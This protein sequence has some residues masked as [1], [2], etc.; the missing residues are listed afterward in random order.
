LERSADVRAV[1]PITL[2]CD[3]FKTSSAPGAGVAFNRRFT[4]P[5]IT[6]SPGFVASATDPSGAVR[7]LRILPSAT[8]CTQ[9]LRVAASPISNIQ[10]VA[11]QEPLLKNINVYPSP[12]RGLVNISF[13]R[14]ELQNAVITVTDQSGRIVYQMRNK[15]ESNLVQLNLQHLSNGIYFIR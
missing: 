14:S 8:P 12:S 6:L 2:S 1:N 15:S 10:N 5:A 13:N 9:A 3:A 4:A 11:T 7:T